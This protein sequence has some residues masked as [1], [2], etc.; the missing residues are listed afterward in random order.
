MTSIKDGKADSRRD[1]QKRGIVLEG[2]AMRG[3]FTAGILDVMME[4][5]IEPDGLVG[6]SAGAAFGC[7]YK[8]HQPGRA[9]R[10]NMRFACDKRYCGIGSLL[11][12]GNIFNAEFAYHIVPTQYDLFDGET[13]EQNRMEFHLVCTD[14]ETGQAVYKKCDSS[15]HEFFDWVR[16]SA[17]MPVVSRIV[18]LGNMKL[19]D[20]GVADSIPLEYFESI[21]YSRNLVILTQP[22]GYVKRPSR[23]MTMIKMCL[24][25]YPKMVEA[26][27][28]RHEMYNAQTE[29][30]RQAEREGRCIVIRPDAPL[31][32][33]HISHNPDEMWKVYS[34]GRE[35]GLKRINEIKEF[36][37]DH[38]KQ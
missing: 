38:N 2:G 5:G 27:A 37:L 9:V 32:I 26:M 19:L 4:H 1:I 21:G 11:R 17:S 8:S 16:A 6:V 13:F 31:P 33:G 12:T 35:A 24:R 7:N 10:Y 29:Y 34:I 30:V 25:K 15:G 23:M 18:E 20:G 28:R 22:E 36:F 3:M 14:V